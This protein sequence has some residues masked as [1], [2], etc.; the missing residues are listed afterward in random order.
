M[1]PLHVIGDFVREW[2]LTVPLPAV[3]GLFIALPAALLVWVLTLPREA[4]TP[5]EG[6]GRWDE[7][8]KLGAGLAL[9]VQ[10]LVY[11]LL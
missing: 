3:R 11:C 5:P 4:T 1:T 7:N 6:A 2:M 10:I 9:V 8:L